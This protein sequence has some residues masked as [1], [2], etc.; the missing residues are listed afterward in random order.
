[1]PKVKISNAR[2]GAD[3][4]SEFRLAHVAGR[5]AGSGV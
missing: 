5:G 1:M 4:K 2:M 3:L